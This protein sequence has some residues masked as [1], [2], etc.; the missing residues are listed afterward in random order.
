MNIC[1]FGDSRHP[2]ILYI[3][4]LFMSGACLQSIASRMQQYHFVCVTLDGYDSSGAEFPGLEQ[5]C[6]RIAKMAE[7]EEFYFIR[8]GNGNVA[9]DD[10]CHGAGK[11]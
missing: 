8:A 10:F 11:V 1:E 9:W 5:E 6:T 3:P 2:H 4:G 7:G